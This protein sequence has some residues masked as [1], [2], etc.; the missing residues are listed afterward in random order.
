[1]AYIR[2]LIPCA[3]YEIKT[4]EAWLEE[5]AQEEGLFLVSCRRAFA[6]FEK[7]TPKPMRYRV[8]ADPDRC[9]DPSR[10]RQQLYEEFGCRK[11]VC[12]GRSLCSAFSPYGCFYIFPPA[13]GFTGCTIPL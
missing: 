11:N 2:R 13:T 6:K 7:G 10:E 9:W 12:G 8:D 5:L 4:F 3:P 1:M